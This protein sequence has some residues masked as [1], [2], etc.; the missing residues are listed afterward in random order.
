[1]PV[2]QNYCAANLSEALKLLLDRLGERS[3]YMD[4]VVNDNLTVAHIY[5]ATWK[6]L[7]DRELVKVREDIGCR[8]YQLTGS[9]WREAL[10]LSGRLDA[11]EFREPFERLNAVLENLVNGRNEGSFAQTHIVAEQ[12]RIPEPWLCNVLESRIWEYEHRR[13]SAMLDDSKTLV[14]VPVDFNLPLPQ[15]QSSAPPTSLI[16]DIRAF[17]GRFGRVVLGRESSIAR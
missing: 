10:K 7:T 4:E 1:M 11:P 17:L 8:R 2:P 12:A 6:E 5:Q 14:I 3:I 15:S 16:K 13:R 9:G